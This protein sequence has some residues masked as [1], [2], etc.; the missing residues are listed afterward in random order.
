MN[1]LGQVLMTILIWAILITLFLGGGITFFVTK[2]AYNKPIRSKVRLTPT[3]ELITDG[4]T[5]DT[6][7]IYNQTN[8]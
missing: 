5:I 1:N 4:K 8:P 2:Y 3:I 7:F 6:V